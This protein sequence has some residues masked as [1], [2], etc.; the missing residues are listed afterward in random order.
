M[1]NQKRLFDLIKPFLANQISAEEFSSKYEHSYNF[2]IDKTSLGEHAQIFKEIFDLV[3]WH[4]PY[5]DEESNPSY[6][7]DEEVF[8]YVREKVAKLNF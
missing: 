8:S 4:S 1:K 6:K 3:V 7:N 2:E 5:A